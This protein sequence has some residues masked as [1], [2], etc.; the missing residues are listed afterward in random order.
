MEEIE[1]LTGVQHRRLS[2]VGYQDILTG[3]KSA[4][5]D[6]KKAALEL[7]AFYLGRLLGL[8]VV[9]WRP[10]TAATGDVE[11]GAIMESTRLA[12]SRWQVWCT[13]ASE[14]SL[15]DIA[16]EVGFAQVLKSNVILIVTTGRVS[17][18]V[19]RFAEQVMRGTNLHVTLVTGTDL[20]RLRDSPADITAVVGRQT[21]GA[22]IAK[23][24]QR[25]ALVPGL[26]SDEFPNPPPLQIDPIRG[27]GKGS[28]K[29]WLFFPLAGGGLRR[30][31]SGFTTS[32][33]SL[34]WSVNGTDYYA[35]PRPSFRRPSTGWGSCSA[36]AGAYHGF[37]FQTTG[38]PL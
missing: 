19:R 16:I 30:I 32:R 24:G 29:G 12:F 5:A 15:D 27:V 22:M 33:V 34:V 36:A 37:L 23:K 10:R 28:R 31:Q 21:Q 20:A 3:L 2:R 13:T 1:V 6:E 38:T 11:L 14:V 8:E 17:T 35:N 9:E 26:Q 7:L 18:T 25:L 4:S